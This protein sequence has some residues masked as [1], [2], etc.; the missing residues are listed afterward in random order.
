MLLTIPKFNHIDNPSLKMNIKG[1]KTFLFLYGPL[2]DLEWGRGWCLA[3]SLNELGHEVH[4]LNCQT[5]GY[6]K[7]TLSD[8]GVKVYKNG[9]GFPF[10]KFPLLEGMNWFSQQQKAKKIRSQIR[11]ADYLVFNG[12]PPKSVID[13]WIKKFPEAKVLYDCADSKQDMFND[14]GNTKAGERIKKWEKYLVSKCDFISGINSHVLKGLDPLKKIPQAKFP[15]GVSF[16]IKYSDHYLNS[17]KIKLIY[18]GDMGSRLDWEQLV[19]VLKTCP[20]SWSLDLYGPNRP[21]CKELVDLPSVNYKGLLPFNDL[22]EIMSEYDFGVLPYKDLISIRKSDPLKI[23]QY[24]SAG[25]PVLA[26]P[27]KG[28][29]KMRGIHIL[30]KDLWNLDFFSLR[31]IPNV[32]IKWNWKTLANEWMAC[33]DNK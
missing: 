30:N 19:K 15:N 33:F 4:Y 8:K 10:T 2:S 17:P 32:G 26:F 5:K 23:R 27:Y 9:F 14:F 22:M 1:H 16:N 21:D 7:K 20:F 18:C 3:S 29:P 25:L 28:L 11:S 6:Q 24:L 31:P 13:T 12:V